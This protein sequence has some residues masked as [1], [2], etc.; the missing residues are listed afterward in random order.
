MK[1]VFIMSEFET[2]DD[3]ELKTFLKDFFNKRTNPCFI[4]M[5]EINDEIRD[6]V[7][8]NE[9]SKYLLENLYKLGITVNLENKSVSITD[10]ELKLI[11][12]EIKEIEENYKISLRN[13]FIEKLNFEEVLRDENV[14]KEVEDILG[15]KI[16][17][18]NDLVDIFSK[19]DSN[20]FYEDRQFV[21]NENESR[22]INAMKYI[23]THSNLSNEEISLRKKMLIEDI[24]N[25]EDSFIKQISDIP[26]NLGMEDFFSFE[27]PN[28]CILKTVREGKFEKLFKELDEKVKILKESTSQEELTIPLTYNGVMS[29]TATKAPERI[30]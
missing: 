6:L 29:I 22:A 19:V 30:Y 1:E 18:V 3:E 9:I 8:N 7:R 11:G 2:P 26:K 12:D 10:E 14:L 17:S 24:V 15:I 28:E 13:I 16:T 4:Q 21:M 20:C 27:I 23:L 25:V 5:Q